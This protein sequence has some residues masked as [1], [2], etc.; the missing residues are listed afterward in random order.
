MA[1]KS[2]GPLLIPLNPGDSEFRASTRDPVFS[3]D[4]VQTCLTPQVSAKVVSISIFEG[5]QT[6]R[7]GRASH[8]KYSI[9]AGV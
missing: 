4:S 3:S 5:S 8:R 2:S 7:A 6:K 9:S 1:A